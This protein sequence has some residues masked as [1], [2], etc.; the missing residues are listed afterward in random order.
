MSGGASG[1]ADE[2]ETLFEAMK[3]SRPAK[4]INERPDPLAFVVECVRGGQSV[5]YGE[6]TLGSD[7]ETQKAMFYRRLCR[8]RRPFVGTAE[9]GLDRAFCN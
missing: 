8:V 4:S 3:L 1:N 5:S 7:E 9:R 2:T 6:G